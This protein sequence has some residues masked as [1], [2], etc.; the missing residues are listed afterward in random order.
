MVWTS[1]HD[2]H[3]G[4]G[5][6]LEWGYIYIEAPEPEAVVI[7]QN[8]FGRNPHRMTCTHCGSDY[9]VSEECS[10]AQVTGFQR[11]CRCLDTPRRL[12]GRFEKPTDWAFHEHYYLEDGEE[13]PVGYEASEERFGTRPYVPLA[14]YIKRPGVK[15]IPASEI[16]PE[17]RAGKLRR[18]GYVWVEPEE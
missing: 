10:L 1:F 12:D 8:A 9:S 14:E 7:F 15:V 11:G 16:R 18:E 5:Q 4:G 17:W 13:P 2:M 6:K 3:S